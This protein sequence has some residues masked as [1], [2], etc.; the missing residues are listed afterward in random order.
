M[1]AVQGSSGCKYCNNPNG[2][3]EVVAFLRA[4]G[5]RVVCIDQ[6]PV[7]G[8][9]LIWTAV[10]HGAEDMA[11]DRPRA[12]RAHWLRHASL[13]VGLSSGLAW[14]AWAAECPASC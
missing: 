10:P 14:L 12:E 7:H 1:I 4:Q 6:K 9:G 8:S 2:W 11:G 5:Y 3:R 13:F